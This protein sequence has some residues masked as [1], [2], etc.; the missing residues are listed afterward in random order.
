MISL[1]GL[2][3]GAIISSGSALS[4]FAVEEN[5]AEYAEILGE[6]VEC[7]TGSPVEL[8]ECLRTKTTDELIIAQNE[9]KKIWAFPLRTAPVVDAEWR[10]EEA[11][12]P[13]DPETL[14]DAGAFVQVPVLTGV[15][16][17]EGVWGAAI[18]YEDRKE[19]LTH[20]EYLREE[21]VPQILT[22]M[23]DDKEEDEVV[24]DAIIGQYFEAVQ[25]D[26]DDDD[27]ENEPKFNFPGLADLV[28][29]ITIYSGHQAM[30]EKFA[31]ANTTTYNYLFSHKTPQS[32]SV[33]STM[34]RNMKANQI[35]HPLMDNG[36]THLDDH[37]Y[38]FE[39]V[40]FVHGNINQRLTLADEKV[41]ET[42]LRIWT[43]FA[44]TG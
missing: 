28:G 43:S 23:T 21:L 16:H 8:A 41:A 25:D 2:F 14:M 9:G 32:P 24:T 11:F 6:N 10:G 39:P 22:E 26:A 34:V 5:P 40:N 3:Q 44:A 30:L 35:S 13:D 19:N 31:A 37:F 1:L 20:P 7:P 42:M 12:L 33:I 38:L 29:D 4:D 36:V 18:I 17:D 15:T 27:A